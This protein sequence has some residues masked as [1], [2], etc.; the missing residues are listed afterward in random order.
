MI[1]NLLFPVLAYLLIVYM[2][3]SC[4]SKELFEINEEFLIDEV[5]SDASNTSKIQGNLNS[6]VFKISGVGYQGPNQTEINNLPAYVVKPGNNVTSKINGAIIIASN[7]ITNGKKGGRVILNAGTYVVDKIN[8]KSNVH[9]VLKQGVVLRANQTDTSKKNVVKVVFGIG[10]GE[11]LVNVSIVG[12]GKGKNRPKIKYIRE[13]ERMKGGSRAFSIGRVFNLFIQNIVIQDDQTRF[14]GIA[15]GFKKGNI[16]KSGRATN[17]TIDNVQQIN[18]SYGYGLVQA[19]AGANMLFSNLTCSGGVT[20]RIETDNRFNPNIRVGVDNIQIKNVTNI[21][22]KAA[23]YLKPHSIQNGKVVVD[24]AFSFGSQFAVEIREGTSGTTGT[25]ASGTSIKNVS[26][27]YALVTT[28]HFS[29]RKSIPMCLLPYFKASE[30]DF[31]KER[32]GAKKGPSISAIGNYANY[33]TIDVS[34]VSASVPK[35]TPASNKVNSRKL[36]VNGSAYRG[37]NPARQCGESA[38]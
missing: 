22:G 14:S 37:N 13:S 24:G 28:V 30:P 33:A 10:R 8:L 23:V 2:I 34:S 15:F 36:I 26:A 16:T 35:N 20:A 25:F 5:E 1:K 4:S 38:Y 7:S 9:I 21:K 31:D 11:N 6:G 3:F 18:A 17:V 27:Q 32:I 12:E 29:G 19:N